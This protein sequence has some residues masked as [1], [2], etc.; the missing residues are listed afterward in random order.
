MPDTPQP[1]REEFASY[2]KDYD[3]VTWR[4][5]VPHVIYLGGLALYVFVIRRID[6]DG[7]FL[8]LSLAGAVAYLILLPYFAIKSHRARKR[9]FFRCPECGDWFGQDSS[10]AYHGPNPKF[11]AVLYTGKCGKCGRQILAER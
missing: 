3:T 5:F 11:R 10:G 4:A 6:V 9:Q 2:W 1:T 8:L 7:R